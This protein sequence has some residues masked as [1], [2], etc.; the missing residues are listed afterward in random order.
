MSIGVPRPALATPE[1]SERAREEGDAPMEV[2]TADVGDLAADGVDGSERSPD[3]DPV[4]GGHE[5]HENRHPDADP[6]SDHLGGLLDAF[7]GP[8]DDDG[9]SVARRGS[10][11]VGP[12]L[13]IIDG[14]HE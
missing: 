3:H 2:R 6:P 13:A 7:E 14:G 9:Q 5:K 11:H 1:T 4:G 12:E 8:T 10:M